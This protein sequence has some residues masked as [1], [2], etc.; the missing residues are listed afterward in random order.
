MDQQQVAILIRDAISNFNGIRA[1]AKQYVDERYWWMTDNQKEHK[2]QQVT[3]RKELADQINLLSDE[4]AEFVAGK[5]G[6][7]VE[8]DQ[9]SDTEYQAFVEGQREHCHC[10]DRYSP[11]DGVLAGGMCDGIKDEEDEFWDF[12]E[13]D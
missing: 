4:I 8:G 5:L 7:A 10:S 3:E 12:D 2:V 13:F 6:D 11:C 1:D 9:Q